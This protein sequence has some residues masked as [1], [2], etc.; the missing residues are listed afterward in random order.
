MGCFLN[1]PI[2]MLV[3]GGPV[4]GSETAVLQLPGKRGLGVAGWQ[5]QAK[6]QLY[7]WLGLIKHKATVTP[8]QTLAYE[9]NLSCVS[10]HNVCATW[11]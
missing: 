6:L 9:T 3:S 1:E 5:I 7:L 11:L 10:E 2:N 8:L 4:Q